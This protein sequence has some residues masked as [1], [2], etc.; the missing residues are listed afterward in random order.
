[1]E[2]TL[3]EIV[4]NVSAQLN[5]FD[6]KKKPI[7]LNGVFERLVQVIEDKK[8]SDPPCI[9]AQDYEGAE[10][11]TQCVGPQFDLVIDGG[12]CE[13]DIVTGIITCTQPSVTLTKT[14]GACNL[15]YTSPTVI[16]D[17]YCV[18][19]T[20]YGNSTFGTFKHPAEIFNLEKLLT[21]PNPFNIDLSLYTATASASASPVAKPPANAAQEKANS[22][23]PPSLAPA[24]VPPPKQAPLPVPVPAPV[25]APVSAPAPTPNLA[26]VPAP[27]PKL[28]PAPGPAGR[29]Q[30]GAPEAP[31]SAPNAEAAPGLP[32]QN[33]YTH[34]EP[35]KKA[36]DDALAA[37][38]NDFP[39]EQ[40]QKQ[41]ADQALTPQQDNFA[42]EQAQKKAA[43]EAL[44]QQQAAGGAQK[45]SQ[46]AENQA[47]NT[48]QSAEALTGQ[49]QAAS[50]P[51]GALLSA[52][53]QAPMVAEGPLPER[54]YPT[55]QQIF[56]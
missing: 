34:E 26:P 49:I 22:P 6:Y 2:S 19:S 53:V 10:I 12:S 3:K 1:M 18:M 4:G 38:Q 41:A 45:A 8:T 54:P 9:D 51:A 14:P 20:T 21:V 30:P 29:P 56:G 50:P 5:V 25:P 35:Q 15:K 23:L 32:D 11:P 40:A 42:H 44:A 48:E 33:P 36:A 16:Q 31:E 39:H 17:R 7:N 24:P 46:A 13:E 43:D 37:Q 55:V 27:G 47:T 52:L 28:A